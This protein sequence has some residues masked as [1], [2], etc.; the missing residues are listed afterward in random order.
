MITAYDALKRAVKKSFGRWYAT[1]W[2]TIED[3]LKDA[4]RT[5]QAAQRQWEEIFLPRISGLSIL[6]NADGSICIS[7]TLS[8]PVT[9]TVREENI[10]LLHSCKTDCKF[11]VF[12]S[13]DFDEKFELK[14]FASGD[15]AEEHVLALNK[16]E[17]VLYSF[18]FTQQA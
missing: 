5:G 8:P 11:W 17:D 2:D 13:L 4:I 15:K 18:S 10:R 12:A 6:N 14:G 3:E 1:E 7:G 16:Y 9:A